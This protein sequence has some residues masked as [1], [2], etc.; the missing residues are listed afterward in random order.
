VPVV[1]DASV[2]VALV[3]AHRSRAI[4]T[5]AMRSRAIGGD[6]VHAPELLR[7]EVTSALTQQVAAGLLPIDDVPALCAPPGRRRRSPPA[8]DR[9]GRLGCAHDRAVV[10]RNA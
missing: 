2:V 7:Y 9:F 10:S 5:R 4:A 3:T 6:D 1:L 8:A